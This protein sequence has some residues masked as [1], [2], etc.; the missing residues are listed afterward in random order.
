MSAQTTPARNP[1]L[2]AEPTDADRYGWIRAAMERDAAEERVREAAP[3]MLAALRAIKL[4][5]E[6]DV[7]VDPIKR[8][9]YLSVVD[10]AIAKAEGRA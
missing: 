4:N 8:K 3:V 9:M 2:S 5:M 1:T 6:D 7:F 10:A